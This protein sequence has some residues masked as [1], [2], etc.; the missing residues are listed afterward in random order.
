[1]GNQASTGDIYVRGMPYREDNG[2]NSDEGYPIYNM[3]PYTLYF[4]FD[5]FG[6]TIKRVGGT[7]G[8]YRTDI[9]HDP[10]FVKAGAEQDSPVGSWHSVYLS[11]TF[12]VY[13]Q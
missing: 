12:T 2:E 10:I 1:M 5:I 6:A 7:W 4:M 9:D 11:T 3:K 8:F 13:L